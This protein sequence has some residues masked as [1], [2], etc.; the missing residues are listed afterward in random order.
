M[1]QNL[2]NKNYMYVYVPRN[3]IFNENKERKHRNNNFRKIFYYK[4][5]RIYEFNNDKIKEIDITNKNEIQHNVLYKHI[6]KSKTDTYFDWFY[7]LKE[8]YKDCPEIY[9][10]KN[11][12]KPRI[13]YEDNLNSKIVNEYILQPKKTK[14]E[15]LT[16][17]FNF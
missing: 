8:E 3:K 2:L 4:N 12:T 7:I 16:I 13:S 6:Y 5:K 14:S 15:R 11:N 1:N 9:I 10:E 17:K